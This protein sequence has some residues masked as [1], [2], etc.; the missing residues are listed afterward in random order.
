MIETNDVQGLLLSG[1]A[2]QPCAAY[3]FLSLR[4]GVDPRGWLASLCAR[5]TSGGN[6]DRQ[7]QTSINVAF[8]YKG[9]ARLGLGAATLTTFSRQFIEDMSNPVRA[10]L[11]GDEPDSWVWGKPDHRI[12]ILLMLFARDT[13]MLSELLK[14]ERREAEGIL[15]EVL[16][17]ES[18][19]FPFSPGSRL[20]HEHFGFVDGLAQPDLAGYRPEKRVPNGPGND[21]KVGEFILGYENEYS[22]QFTASPRIEAPDADPGAILPAGD[23]GRNGTYLVVRQ[24][25]QDVAGFWNM[26]REQCARQDGSPNLEA[27]EALAAKIVGRWRDGTPVTVSPDHDG[28]DPNRLNDFGF[29]EDAEGYRCPLGAHIRRANPREMLLADKTESITTLKRHR[30]LR[31]GRPYG[32]R[33]ADRYSD[34]GQSRGLVFATLNANIERQFEFVQQAWLTSPNFAGLYDEADPMLGG[35]TENAG[36]FTLPRCPVRKRRIGILPHVAVKGGA[37]FFMPGLMALRYL[38]GFVPKGPPTSPADIA[39]PNPAQ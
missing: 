5:I 7:R 33:I 28:G 9:F 26:L 27:E 11:L 35:R 4:D 31:R 24:M 22:G 29:S 12:Q 36:T 38:S 3:L 21:V 18:Q 1:Y 19:V 2:S 14:A 32:P 15:D 39:A 13:P 16:A 10:Q 30:L 20:S 6:Y 23:L 34:D 37:Y 25:E 8:S 17:I